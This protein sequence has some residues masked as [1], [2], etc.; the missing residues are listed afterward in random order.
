MCGGFSARPPNDR[1]RHYLP[2]FMRQRKMNVFRLVVTI[3]SDKGPPP[4]AAVIPPHTHVY[5]STFI[6]ETQ[7]VA[8]HLGQLFALG[9]NY[10]AFCRLRTARCYFWRGGCN[11]L[12]LDTFLYRL[13]PCTRLQNSVVKELCYETQLSRNSLTK[14]FCVRIL[15]ENTMVSVTQYN[16]Q[17]INSQRTLV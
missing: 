10:I 1:L 3:Y 16:N 2:E 12:L 6:I 13:L 8:L 14:G 17:G 7:T 9:G 4:T 5:S 11:C 15:L